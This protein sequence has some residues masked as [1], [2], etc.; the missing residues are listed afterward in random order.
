MLMQQKAEL[1]FMQAT[2]VEVLSN[3]NEIFNIFFI[4][5]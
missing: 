5:K 1:N 3:L 2:I 4:Y